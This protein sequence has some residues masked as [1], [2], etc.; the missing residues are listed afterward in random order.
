MNEHE[1]GISDRSKDLCR[2]ML[3]KKHAPPEN[4]IFYDEVFDEA[5]RKLR[6]KNEARIIQDIARLLVPSA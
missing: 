3:E 6:N 5:C 4:T 1:L 2:R